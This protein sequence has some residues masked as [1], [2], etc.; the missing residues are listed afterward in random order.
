MKVAVGADHAGFHLKEKLAAFLAG[1]GYEV[2]DFGADSDERSDYPDYAE[3]VALAVTGGD[4]D[5]GIAICGSGVGVCIAAN[6]VE[7]IRA[8]L[9]HDVYSASQ[10]VQHDNMN[11]LCFGAQIVGDKLAERL[12]LAFLNAEFDGVPRHQRRI[13]KI[14]EIEDRN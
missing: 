1:E 13:D 4:A 14:A 7:G 10:G 11:V 6:K 9:C 2:L 5:R 12:A 8:C 3:K